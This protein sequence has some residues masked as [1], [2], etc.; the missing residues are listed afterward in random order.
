MTKAIDVGRP[1]MTAAPRSHRPLFNQGAGFRIRRAANTQAPLSSLI[2]PVC[3]VSGLSA[4]R[5]NVG[6]DKWLKR[7][8]S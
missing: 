5:V 3:V 4:Y 7:L 2:A 8:A 1:F 6:G